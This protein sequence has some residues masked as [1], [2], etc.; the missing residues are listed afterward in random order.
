MAGKEIKV[1]PQIADNFPYKLKPSFV[2]II[3]FWQKV[4]KDKQNYQFS[5]AKQL[6]EEVKKVPE[7]LLPI[8]D[9][10]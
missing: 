4:A 5:F 7:L 6:I 3:K 2:S 1:T 10:G 9:F 8:E